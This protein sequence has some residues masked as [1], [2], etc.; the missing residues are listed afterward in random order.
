M[1]EAVRAREPRDRPF[2][3]TVLARLLDAAGEDL[4]GDEFLT[5]DVGGEI[6]SRPPGKWNVASAGTFAPSP[7]SEAA[8]RQRI[9]TPPNR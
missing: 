2:D 5:L 4:V 6:V 8:Q 1:D 3:R 7:I 9:S